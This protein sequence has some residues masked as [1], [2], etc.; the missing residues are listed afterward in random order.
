M[1]K[2]KT[3]PRHGGRRN[4]AAMADDPPLLR[5]LVAQANDRGD[6]LADLGKV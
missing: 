5:V 4:P 1:E 2:S 6:T 3:E